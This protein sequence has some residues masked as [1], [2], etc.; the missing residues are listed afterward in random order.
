MIAPFFL[1]TVQGFIGNRLGHLADIFKGK[2]FA[3]HGA[4]AVGTKFN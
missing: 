1:M 3:N 4:P 2:F